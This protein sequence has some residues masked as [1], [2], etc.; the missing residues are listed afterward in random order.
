MINR[1]IKILAAL[2][3]TGIL[4][5]K[6]LG[7]SECGRFPDPGF[8]G[9]GNTAFKGSY[10][11]LNYLYVVTIPNG[12]VGYSSPPPSP[13][14]GFGIV[15]SWE[16]RAY[17]F[18]DSSANSLNYNNE[19]EALNHH[20]EYLQKE[21]EHIVSRNISNLLLGK[22]QAKMQEIH[23]KCS[24]VSEERVRFMVVSL[25]NGSSPVDSA[26]MDTTVS[27]LGKDLM[28]YYSI[29]KSW[30]ITGTY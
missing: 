7:S 18:V 27:R 16:P 26:E 8:E 22:T 2:L 9:G 13:Q 20:M 4:P 12:L 21:A 1:T 5:I 24:G 25:R 15:L 28:V 30:R 19:E 6:A 14:H 17:L 23:Y 10:E 29:I 3:L 11:N